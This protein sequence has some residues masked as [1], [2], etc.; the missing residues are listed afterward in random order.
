LLLIVGVVVAV[1]VLKK[2]VVEIATNLPSLVQVASVR[3]LSGDRDALPVLGRVRSQTEATIQTEAQG[4]VTRVLYSLGDYVSAGAV[5]AELE[6]SSQRAGVAKAQ[7]TLDKLVKSASREEND[8]RLEAINTYRN[9]FTTASD[10]IFNRADQF[11][12]NPQTSAPRINI[13]VF[14]IEDID[15]RRAQIG[16]M[17]A[18][19]QRDLSEASLTSDLLE[20]LDETGQ[21]MSVIQE[22]LIDLSYLVNRQEVSSTLTQTTLDS[23]K[24]SMS[25][26]RTQ[27]DSAITNI[28]SVKNT[29]R[30]TQLVSNEGSAVSE[31]YEDISG[32][33]ATLASAQATL[34]KTIVRAPISGTINML[35]LERGDFVSA[36]IPVVTVANNTALQVESF[37]AEGDRVNIRV[38]GGVLIDGRF[39]G[40]ITRIAPALD[41]RTKKIEIEIGIE[42]T[43]TDLTS[44]ESVEVL[45]ERGAV[46]ADKELIEIA[47]PISALKVTPEGIVVFTVDSNSRLVAH[48]IL[49]GPIIGEKI[50]IEEG[51]TPEMFIVLDARGLRDGQEVEVSSR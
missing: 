19:W 11:F 36:F 51:I 39:R 9:S 32:A 41:P 1:I 12:E 34:E 16:E 46:D 14:G 24:A 20:Q 31:K 37:I 22:F 7:A 49:E 29:L 15:E 21:N 47:I 18:R 5:I 30:S 6:N 44:G 26:A 3:S 4:Q 17:L 13:S 8:A 45:L 48:P 23:Q 43:D 25:T 42:D 33:E 50:I 40:V 10:V 38:G 27:V 2:D 28:T 35:A